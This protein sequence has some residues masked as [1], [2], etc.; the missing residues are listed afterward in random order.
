MNNRRS[1]EQICKECDYIAWHE[2][3]GRIPYRYYGRL[4]DIAAD[5]NLIT[6]DINDVIS[7]VIEHFPSSYDQK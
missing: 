7:F 6:F 4:L 5:N 3:K 1:K 2:F